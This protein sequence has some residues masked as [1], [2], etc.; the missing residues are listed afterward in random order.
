[1]V[2][3]T[4]E[5]SVATTYFDLLA[6]R[7]RLEIAN[8]DLKAAQSILDALKKRFAQG[9]ASELDVR[10]EE[11]VV[12]QSTAAIPPLK[13]QE[14]RDLDALAILLGTLPESVKSPEAKLTDVAAPAVPE[15]LPSQLLERRPDVQE[16]EAQLIA[17]H[18]DINAARAAFF[19]DISLTG[20]AG[21]ASSSLGKLFGPGGFLL[22]FGAGL[23][24]PIFEGGLL[25][26][27][28]ALS[29]AQ[30]EE[31]EQDY[32][33]SVVSAFSDVEDSLAAVKDTADQEAA[34]DEAVKTA[35]RAYELS[36]QQFA[37]GTVDIT[38]VL[39]TQR[40]LFSA[41]DALAQARLAHLQAIAGLYKSLGGGWGKRQ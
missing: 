1:M 31:L 14:S 22:S 21:Y 24:Q 41:T 25:T 27:E 13:L 34:Q 20:E 16:A 29:K 33:K 3:L 10:Q 2:T 12:D 38:S 17:A 8:N 9:V 40:T 37:G 19:P 15:G 7:Q 6:T 23:V 11:S 30:Y 36:Q 32:K 28:L 35:Q 39:N 4:V 5:S 18:A 26:G